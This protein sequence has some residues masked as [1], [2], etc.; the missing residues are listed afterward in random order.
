LALAYYFLSQ[1]MPHVVP[2]LE[3]RWEEIMRPAKELIAQ[4][5]F[6]KKW[7]ETNPWTVKNVPG[8]REA[9]YAIENE[10]R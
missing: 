4:S 8:M 1:E 9:V 5:K 2:K 6:L 7:E 3:S 10:G